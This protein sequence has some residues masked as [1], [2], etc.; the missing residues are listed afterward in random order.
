MYIDLIS[1]YIY[2]ASLARPQPSLNLLAFQNELG[3]RENAWGRS[4]VCICIATC[5]HDTHTHHLGLR[6]NA[7]KQEQR[8][9]LMAVSGLIHTSIAIL[10]GETI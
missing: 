2:V 6:L 3:D 7:F 9:G 5:A 10:S 8:Y 1:E 4:Y